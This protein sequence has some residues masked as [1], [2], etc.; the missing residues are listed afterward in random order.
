VIQCDCII[1]FVVIERGGV[2][3]VAYKIL[4]VDD[5]ADIRQLLQ[6][7]FEIQGY[8]VFTA[9]DGREA[10]QKITK[11][12]DIILL[13][14]NMP[15][16][17]GIEVC[18]RIRDYVACPIVFLTAKVEETDRINGL[19]SGGDDYITKPFSIDEL[20]VRISAHLRREMRGRNKKEVYFTENLAI[21]YSE[22]AI[23]Y[24]KQ[25]ISL[26]KKEF[27]IMELLSMNR[28]QIFGRERI[29]EKLWGYDSE[30]DSNIVTEHVRR[31]RSKIGKYTEKSYIETVWGMGYKWVD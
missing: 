15:D 29:Y 18:K 7:Y 17:D 27:D 31:I 4:V 16:V 23:Y 11:L 20:G 9:K 12:P 21:N 26:T 8:E 25:L 1:F 19:I 2:T 10:M 14:I 30:G 28:G 6:D 22:R 5:E 24:Q 13:D 3:S